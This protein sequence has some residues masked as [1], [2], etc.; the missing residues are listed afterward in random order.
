MSISSFSDAILTWYDLY[1][2]KHLPWQQEKTAY[3]VWLSEI[4]LQQTQV[5]TVIPYFERFIQ[6]F[7]KVEELAKAEL[8]EVLHLWTGLGYYARARNLHKTAIRLCEFYQGQFPTEIDELIAL[9]GIG[10]ST[11]GAILSFAFKKHHPILDGNV[12]RTL[13][14]HFAIEGWPQKKEIE[15]KL[16]QLA[17]DN[18]PAVGVEKYNQAMMDI[19]SSICTRTKPKCSLCPVMQS[20][21]AFK[22]QKQTDFPT[23]KPSKKLPE[24]NAYFVI[25]QAGNE[26]WLE[27]R[28]PTGLWGGLWSLPETSEDKLTD[29]L[30]ER[31]AFSNNL[32]DINLRKALNQIEHLTAFRHTFSH[33]HLNIHPVRVKIKNKE[34]LAKNNQIAEANGALWYNLHKPEKVG[35]ATPVKRL[36]NELEKETNKKTK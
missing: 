1:G 25:F 4:M 10:R 14:R 18:T 31:L 22:L 6:R 20:C 34:V 30:Q 11:A 24:K 35:L 19:G 12:K 8:D 9:P 3:K 29:W 13:T 5:T 26:V 16:W 15:K 28:P 17:T 33:F 36:L 2:R 7:P 23:P 27:Q 32:S 21:Q